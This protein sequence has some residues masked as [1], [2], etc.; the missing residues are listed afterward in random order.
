MGARPC[1]LTGGLEADSPE[2]Q[3]QAPSSGQ[4]ALSNHGIVSNARECHR[5]PQYAPSNP[6]IR[7]EVVNNSSENLFYH[8]LISLQ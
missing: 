3:D 8:P 4:D 2:A 6:S 7:F 1:L 5:T